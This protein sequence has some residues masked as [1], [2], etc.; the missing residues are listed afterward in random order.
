MDDRLFIDY[1][2]ENSRTESALFSGEE[3]ARI[4]VLAGER[5]ISEGPMQGWVEC[6]EDR[7]GVLCQKARFYQSE[8]M[9]AEAAFVFNERGE[10]TLWHTPNDRAGGAIPDSYDLWQFLWDTR[11]D[12]G[13]VA[14]THPWKGTTGASGTDITTFSGI[15]LGLGKKLNWLIVTFTHVVMY[16]WAGPGKYDYVLS[17]RRFRVEEGAIEKIRDLSRIP[18]SV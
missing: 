14:H 8:N 2:E 15:E 5:K 11:H 6:H 9:V 10:V 13:G 3:M 16:H 18:G 4:L 12:L 17:P 1:C 7:M